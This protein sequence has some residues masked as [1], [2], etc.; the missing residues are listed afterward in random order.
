MPLVK[1]YAYETLPAWSSLKYYK[2]HCFHQNEVIEL[3]VNYPKVAITVLCGA[4]EITDGDV[5]TLVNQ[6]EVYKANSGHLTVKGVFAPPF[7]FVKNVDILVIGGEWKDADIN[8]FMVNKS[9][10]PS[11]ESAIGKGTPNDYYRNTNFDN[12]YHDFDEF[13]VICEGSGVVQ[14]NGSFFE[15]EEGDCVA[16]GNGNHHDF[17]IVHEFV[18]ALA[19]EVAPE[20]DQRHG[21]L[22]EPVHGKAP[23]NPAK[24]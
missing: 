12:H 17:P 13:W 8:L 16:T 15:V 20:G 4:C 6:Y 2:K 3:D 24:A 14:D 21:H 23:G 11:N 7:Y 18:R 22:W 5:T 19:I 9:D 10:I 1:N